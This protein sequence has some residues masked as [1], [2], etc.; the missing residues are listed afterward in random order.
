MAATTFPKRFELEV[1]T[2]DGGAFSW[3]GKEG[4]VEMS[5][6]TEGGRTRAWNNVYHNSREIGFRVHSP[7][8]GAVMEFTLSKV[9]WYGEDEI[10]GWRFASPDGDIKILIIND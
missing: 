10:A 5:E 4:V 2:H 9:D 8:T 6:L 3:K 1:P 7:Q